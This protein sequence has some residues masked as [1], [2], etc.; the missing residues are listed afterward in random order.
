MTV[1]VRYVVWALVAGV[2]YVGW[3]VVTRR[4]LPTALNT[5]VGV[6]VTVLILACLDAFVF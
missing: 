2:A 6:V 3:N 4:G 1:V 5:A